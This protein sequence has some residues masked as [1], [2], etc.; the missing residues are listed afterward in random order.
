M[1]L[2]IGK[3]AHFKTFFKNTIFV[4]NASFLRYN[5]IRF[6][7]E[8]ERIGPSTNFDI[9]TLNIDRRTHFKI[10][11]KNTIFVANASFSRYNAIHFPEGISLVIVLV[12]YLNCVISQ[13]RSVCTENGILEKCLKMGPSIYIKCQNIEIR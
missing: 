11:F 2:F 5:A 1:T 3:R 10:F 4:A 12:S 7:V 9:L 6:P 13:K 8:G